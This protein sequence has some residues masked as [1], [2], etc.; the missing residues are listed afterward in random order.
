MMKSLLLACAT[1]VVFAGCSS[2]STYTPKQVSAKMP[3]QADMKASL[4]DVG[5]DGATYS[6][7]KIINKRRG[8]L[9]YKEQEKGYHFIYDSGKQILLADA[10]GGVKV[11]ADNKAR[12]SKK[13]DFALSSGAIKGNIA[14]LVFSN[15]TLTLYDIKA[16]KELYSEALEPTFANDARL[17]N[18]L[19]L[20]DLVV[21]PTLDGRLLIMDALRKVVVRDIAISNKKLFNNVIYLNVKNDVLVAATGSKLV[22]IDAKNIQTKSFAVKDVLLDSNGIYL[23]TKVGEVKLLDYQLNVKKEIKFPFAIFAA[24]MQKDK[25]YAVEKGGYLIVMDK[26][27]S[28]YNVYELPEK[29]QKPIFAFKD[30]L[31]VDKNFIKLQ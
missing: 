9:A 17:A 24:V 22:A 3:Y 29:I 31:F 1:L 2:K 21:F 7:G 26:Q 27:L 11:V 14:A 28:N 16:D 20:N 6:D 4:V 5:R 19:F 13:F 10:D 15:N 18:P 8:L 23:F 25:L 12:F 30:R